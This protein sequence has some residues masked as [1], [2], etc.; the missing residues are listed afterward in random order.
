[1]QLFLEGN[2]GLSHPIVSSPT[3]EAGTL[4]SYKDVDS[5][6][7]F[8]APGSQERSRIARQRLDETDLAWSAFPDQEQGE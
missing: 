2:P 3:Q 8:A 4:F 5:I 6:F 1:M 7:T